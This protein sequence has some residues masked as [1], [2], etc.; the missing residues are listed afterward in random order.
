MQ[1]ARYVF[2]LH[3]SKAQL[4]EYYSG[5]VLWVQAESLCGKTLRFRLAHLKPFV[6][7]SG[8]SGRFVLEANSDGE[9][10]SLTRL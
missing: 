5:A 4:L 6:S 9:F 2:D 7:S 3:L 10:R 1:V 8:I